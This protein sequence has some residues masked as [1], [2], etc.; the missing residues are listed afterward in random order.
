MGIDRSPNRKPDGHLML[1][2]VRL[3]LSSGRPDDAIS[4]ELAELLGFDQLEFVSEILSNR[5]QFF[6][7]PRGTQAPP[8]KVTG[9]GIGNSCSVAT[10]GIAHVIVLDPRSLVPNQVRRRMEEQLQA[11]ASRP[12]F[13]GT[14][15][16]HN[17]S[18]DYGVFYAEDNSMKHQKSSPM[19]TLLTRTWVAVVCFLS[20]GVSICCRLGPLER[21]KR[22]GSPLSI[23]PDRLILF[24]SAGL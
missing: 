17:A 4:G 3:I 16:S 19:Y 14:A 15:V 1:D 6:E 8:L 7:E 2:S 10:K 9:D 22:Q 11:N 13:T 21:I 18:S 12:L 24:G 5:S 23:F 20:S